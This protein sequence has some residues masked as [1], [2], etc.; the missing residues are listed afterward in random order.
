MVTAYLGIG[1]NI[2]DR[3]KNLERMRDI[4]GGI[5]GVEVTGVS[6]VYETAPVGVEKQRKF[7]N[8]VVKISTSLAPLQLLS[9][10]KLVEKVLGRKKT[11]RWGPR[12]A[13]IDILLY[14]SKSFRSEKL[15]IPHKEI[16]KRLFVL[17]PL[18]E[19]AP[20]TRI[21]GAGNVEQVLKA[22]I[23]PKRAGKAGVK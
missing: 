16:S 4:L 17:V 23:E 9:A 22:F 12:T 2:G 3:M 15:V 5:K 7:Y 14:G 18:H 6:S 19:L 11:K 1:S 13:D 20:R 10:C 8:A 21:P